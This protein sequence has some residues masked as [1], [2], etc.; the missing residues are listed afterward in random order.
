MFPVASTR[1]H[2]LQFLRILL[3]PALVAVLAGCSTADQE[4]LTSEHASAAAEEPQQS[5]VQ[6]QP[7]APSEQPAPP[8]VLPID[9]VGDRQLVRPLDEQ[10]T[11]QA[12]AAETAVDLWFETGQT[13]EA[14]DA[15]AVGDGRT[16]NTAAFQRMLAGGYRTVHVVAGEYLTGKL[17]IESN[18]MLLLDPGVTLRDNGLLQSNDRLL[19]IRD[20]VNVRITAFGARLVADRS[21][22]LEGE[23]RH[24]VF[25]FGSSH[26][27]IDGLESS[28]HGGDGFYIG[29]PAGSP[30][31][32]IALKGC[33]ADSNRRQGLS[34]T[35]ARRVR[36][37]DCEFSD[38]SGTA[39]QFGIDLEPN[40]RLDVM[41]DILL[42]RTQTAANRGG[43][44]MIH[45]DR[46]QA[47][48][49]PARIIIA[50]HS[51]TSETPRMLVSVPATINP[52][53][54]YGTAP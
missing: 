38:T 15:G 14:V 33:R 27:Q 22:Y 11:A 21:Q 20:K 45:L 24:G 48:S 8:A 10:A 2:S 35:S 52:A 30:S 9:V 44:I 16:D 49:A 1:R 41:E 26:V 36:V 17:E 12:R 37:V 42:V 34:I 54:F 46:L 7:S 23:Q 40:Q 4:N 53:L 5:N 43:G 50:E 3:F 25:I 39:P 29:G 47:T 13:I 28:G 31:S 19:N 6:S 32:D 18:T 51:S